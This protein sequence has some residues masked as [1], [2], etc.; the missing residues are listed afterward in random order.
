MSTRALNVCLPLVSD[1]HVCMVH[2]MI[3]NKCGTGGSSGYHYLR[4]TVRYVMMETN[5]L[6]TALTQSPLDSAGD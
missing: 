6:L 1:N 3:G 2:R 5:L 4:S